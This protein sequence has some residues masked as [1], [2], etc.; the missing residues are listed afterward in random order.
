MCGIRHWRQVGDGAENVRALAD[1]AGCFVVDS[2]CE[3]KFCIDTGCQLDNL[4]ALRL[5]DGAG[6]S[7]IVR[8]QTA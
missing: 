1:N 3:R 2:L 8:M 6:C 5:T 7:G 4:D